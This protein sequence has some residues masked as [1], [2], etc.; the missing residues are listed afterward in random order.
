MGHAL[1]L[2][3]PD[4]VFR[5]LTKI[6]EQIGQS[7]ESLA[8]QWLARTSRKLEVDPLDEFIGAFCSGIPDWADEHDKYIG[9]SVKA[10]LN[11]TGAADGSKK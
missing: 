10:R 7:P 4:D 3:L 5:S 2:E 8:T 11:G 1:Q 9:D 6:A